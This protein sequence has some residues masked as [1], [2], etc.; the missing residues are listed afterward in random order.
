[1]TTGKVVDCLIQEIAIARQVPKM[2]VRINDWQLGI[3]N[4]LSSKSQPF[5]ICP[6]MR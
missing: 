1:M 5:G 6:W 3:D 4:V 2:M